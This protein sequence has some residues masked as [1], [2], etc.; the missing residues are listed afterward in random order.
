MRT[1]RSAEKPESCPDHS[2]S[3]VNTIADELN[4]NAGMVKGRSDEA[5]LPVVKGRHGVKQMCYMGSAQLK[6]FGGCLKRGFGVAQ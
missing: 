5:W 4:R 2:R 3:N 1:M 6:G